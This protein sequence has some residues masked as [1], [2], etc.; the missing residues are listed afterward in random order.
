MIT[1]FTDVDVSLSLNELKGY[2]YRQVSKIRRTL[3]G[4]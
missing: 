1:L 4:N 2:G 3:V